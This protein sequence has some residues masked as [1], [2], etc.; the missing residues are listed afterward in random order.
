MLEP[1]NRLSPKES[2]LPQ[3]GLPVFPAASLGQRLLPAWEPS[4]TFSPYPFSLR[5]GDD[6]ATPGPSLCSQLFWDIQQCL[7]CPRLDLREAQRFWTASSVS[8]HTGVP[9]LPTARLPTR[10]CREQNYVCPPRA[11]EL[12]RDLGHLSHFLDFPVTGAP[13]RVSFRTARGT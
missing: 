4:S 1:W 12:W 2:N 8:P 6:Q 13:Q 11:L 5:P 10:Q 7:G 9:W 3:E